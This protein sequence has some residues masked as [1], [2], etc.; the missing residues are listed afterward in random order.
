MTGA[1]AR[2]MADEYDL[3][4]FDLD[5]V[6]YLGERAIPGAVEAIRGLYARGTPVAYATNNASRRPREVADLLTGLGLPAV[7][8]E[9]TSSPRAAAVLLAQRLPAGAK[10]LVVGT[11]A[12]AEE[13]TAAG[14]TPV[15]LAADEPA[16]VVQGYAPEVGWAVLAEACLAVRAGALWVATNT[17]PTLPS[18]RGLL[19]GNGALVAALA[20]ALGRQPDAVV[21]KPAPELFHSA[22]RRTGARAPLVV[23][24]RLDTDIEGA[25][26]A[27]M[28]AL[29]VLTGVTT[30]ADLVLAV[31]AQ[32]PTY[33]AAD[34]GA[35]GGPAAAVRVPVLAGDGTAVA[36]GG[37]RLIHRDGG[38]SLA[39]GGDPLDALRL[40][41]AAVW[42]GV[43]AANVAADAAATT[44][45]RGLGLSG[46]ELQQLA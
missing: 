17:D 12:L 13:I 3:V 33:I 26:R 28:P 42:A 30:A 32:R 5:G 11:D 27:G 1:P 34:L 16:A 39:G 22:A 14:L 23:G 4:I 44:A 6:V 18:P 38:A 43:P 8:R 29:V 20:T 31:P 10:V 45:L 40:V 41:C 36:A 19:P 46:A 21:G 37:W 35:L 9:V 2:M 15:R 7:A 25:V 24:D